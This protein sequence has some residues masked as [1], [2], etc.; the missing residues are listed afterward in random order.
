MSRLHSEACWLADLRMGHI[1]CDS[2]QEVTAKQVGGGIDGSFVLGTVPEVRIA[3][4]VNLQPRRREHTHAEV[5]CG[6][7]GTEG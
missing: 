2:I 3:L 4:L 7:S 6:P 5:A 1:V